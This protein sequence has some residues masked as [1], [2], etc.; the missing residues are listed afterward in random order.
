MS[1]VDDRALE[2]LEQGDEH[3]V[4]ER[5][6]WRGRLLEAV[7]RNR[8]DLILL[9][10]LVAVTGFVHATNLHG[11]PQYFEDESTYVSQAWALQT[12]GQLSHYTYWYDHPPAGWIQMAIW[13]ALT[14]AWGRTGSGVQVGREIALVAN[15][16]SVSLLFVLARR[17]GMHR[18][19]TAV[20]VL[21]FALSPLSIYF[22]R[23]ALLDNMLL[24]WVLGAFVLVHSPRHRLVA[25]AVAGVCLA[26]AC[27][28]KITAGVYLPILLW[29]GWR[30]VPSASRRYVL[31]LFTAAFALAGSFWLLMALLK[32]ELWPDTP[33]WFPGEDRVSLLGTQRWVLFLRGGSGGWIFDPESGGHYMLNHSLL[34][35]DRWLL[36]GG[37]VAAVLLLAV[38]RHRWAGVTFLLLC[39]SVV[40]STTLSWPFF[41]QFLP[42]AALAIGGVL[43][44]GRRPLARLWSP[45]WAAAT[46]VGVIVAMVATQFVP[47]WSDRLRHAHN[48][49]ANGVYDDAAAWIA[50]HID[51]DQRLLV[52]NTIWIDVVLAGHPRENVIWFW[53]LEHDPEIMEAH[54][55][56]RGFDYV[57]SSSFV[58]D[59]TGAGLVPQM[60]AALENSEPVAEFVQPGFETEGVTVRR[61]VRARATSQPRSDE[62]ATAPRRSIAEDDRGVERPTVDPDPSPS[63][64]D[65]D[66]HD[67]GVLTPDPA[68][69]APPAP[70]RDLEPRIGELVHVV[71]AGDTLWD[72]ARRYGT[73]IE[74]I[75]E[76]NDLPDPR[77][78]VVDQVLV[79]PDPAAVPAP[80]AAT[81]SLRRRRRG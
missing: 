48:H 3:G 7:E 30:R 25:Y 75:A 47:A 28:T 18:V 35:Q 54:G 39:A 63:S 77:L 61:V 55:D 67:P 46:A 31:A 64:D 80:A 34:A 32:G 56:W 66:G 49:D 19:V 60:A 41:A 50:E 68:V 58:R 11:W 76:R 42:W 79:I 16:V 71:V 51:H 10:V 37:L 44:T 22:Q 17:M 36:G 69:P 6:R 23:M 1:V 52:D 72:L 53:K 13:A 8:A 21:L 45:S 14:G 27:Q 65:A 15:L 9:A 20:V 38:R 5:R 40:R 62:N 78:I 33:A 81:E 57:V 59:T 12:Q 70:D 26:I 43:E 74:H 24:P 73:T 29:I 2:P 4:P